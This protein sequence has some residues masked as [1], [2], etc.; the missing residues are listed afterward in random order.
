[1]KKESEL[2]GLPVVCKKNGS[3]LGTIKEIIYSRKK[4]RVLGFIIKEGRIFKDIKIIQFQNIDS[5]GKDAVIIKNE[6]VI[7]KANSLPEIK[8]LL[9]DKKLTEEEVLTESGESIGHVKDILID[10]HKGK[11][12]G[13]ILTDGLFQD[14]KEGRNVLLYSREI[15]FGESSI[16]ISNKDRELFYK[17]K[18]DYKKLLELL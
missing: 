14:L 5:I 2:I 3:K 18:N 11:I 8:E 12:I 16:I 7:E 9:K 1:M 15:F 17:Y 6:A 10:R 4:Y 13:F